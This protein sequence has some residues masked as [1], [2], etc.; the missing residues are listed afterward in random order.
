MD[1]IGEDDI[2]ISALS[3]NRSVANVSQT[4]TFAGEG[5]AGSARG[6]TRRVVEGEGTGSTS[7]FV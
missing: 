2:G 5:W 7:Y 3:R 6:H 4:H 1:N